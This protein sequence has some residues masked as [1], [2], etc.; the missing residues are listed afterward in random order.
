MKLKTMETWWVF[1]K[2]NIGPPSGNRY[3]PFMEE[4]WADDGVALIPG[5]DVSVRAEPL[6]LAN[7]IVVLGKVIAALALSCM[8]GVS[9]AMAIAEV[10]IDAC[11]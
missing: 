9:T 6:P 1:H 2:N 7:G 11:I 5:V 4:D 8:L 10:V 3:V